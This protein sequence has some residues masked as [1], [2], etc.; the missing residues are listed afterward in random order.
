MIYTTIQELLMNLCS[1]EGCGNP[2]KSKG[3][4]KQHYWKLWKYNDP[5]RPTKYVGAP[6]GSRPKTCTIEGCDKKHLGYGYCQQ[7]YDGY[8]KYDDPTRTPN[9]KNPA[10][11]GN[12]T[13]GYRVFTKN[14]KKYREHRF[15]MEQYIGRDLLDH[16]TVHHKNGVRDDNRIENLE[17]WSSAQPYGQ[18]VED[19]V[20][21]AK[22]ILALYGDYNK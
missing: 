17:L 16:E 22:E 14:G 7:H 19:K 20:K 2:H 13:A 15:V 3:Y 9:K 5:H 8:R 18:R 11:E 10:G 6:R 1:I 21:Y 4:C 12:I